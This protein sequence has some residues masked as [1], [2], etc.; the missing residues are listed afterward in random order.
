MTKTANLICPVNSAIWPLR[1]KVYSLT[2][3]QSV[4]IVAELTWCSRILFFLTTG[5]AAALSTDVGRRGGSL[6]RDAVA[7]VHATGNKSVDNYLDI[8]SRKCW[9]NRQQLAELV[10]AA[11]WNSL[12]VRRER[13]LSVEIN[14]KT[15]DA[16]RCRDADV[17]AF[18]TF[19]LSF[20]VYFK[21][22]ISHLFR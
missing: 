14:A 8:I 20:R 10:K 1:V 18:R 9:P 21:L 5:R 17:W 6:V 19:V 13:Q 2:N 11:S 12:H 3:E 16:A 22:F 4:K 7:V 15:R